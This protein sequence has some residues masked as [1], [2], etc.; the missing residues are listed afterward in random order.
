MDVSATPAT[1]PSRSAVTARLPGLTSL[2]S[3]SLVTY[4]DVRRCLEHLGYL[5]YPTLCERDSQAH[6]ITGG[7]P[8]SHPKPS[9]SR[10]APSV[11][12]WLFVHSHA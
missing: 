1:A 10:A 12:P 7:H 11:T 4:L 3:P 6:A 8:P 2:L 5:G 9:P